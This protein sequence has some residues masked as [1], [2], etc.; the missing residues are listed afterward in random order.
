M[1]IVILLSIFFSTITYTY[2]QKDTT[3]Y[4]TQRLKI[5][6]LLTERSAK[7]GQ[8][9]ESLTTRTGIFG[10]QTKKDIKKSNE[11]LRQI[12]LNDNHVFKELKVLLDYKDLEV[13]QVQN[14]MTSTS[15]RVENY[16]QSI[17]KL[18]DQ[19]ELLRQELKVQEDATRFTTV[20][21]V[22]ILAALVLTG[23]L[24]SKKYQRIKR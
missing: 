23:F 16:K 12:V 17:K 22:C 11:I 20:L 19:N 15:N 10:V 7:F 9:D 18:Q 24:L 13:K 8:Y 3:A 1:R 6:A 2:A 4:Q 21:F 5:N 14:T